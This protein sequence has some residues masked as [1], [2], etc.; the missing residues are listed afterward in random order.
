MMCG[1][2]SLFSQTSLAYKLF[3]QVEL[4]AL[5]VYFWLNRYL[6]LII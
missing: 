1:F 2:H 3:N 5:Y 4:K 6:S